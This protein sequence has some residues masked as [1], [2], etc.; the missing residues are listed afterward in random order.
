M[1]PDLDEWALAGRVLALGDLAGMVREDEIRP[2]PMDVDRRPEIANR[3]RATLD[4]PAGPPR[5][6]RTRPR[7]LAGL[8]RLPEHEVQWIFLARIIRI[9]AAL[10]RRLQPGAIA[11]VAAGIRERAEVW[12]APDGKVD[13]AIALVG[14]AA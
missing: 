7:R 12:I 11:N 10:V 14:K 2:A 9:I 5:S 8:L 3:H 13:P 4:V 6:P 1:H